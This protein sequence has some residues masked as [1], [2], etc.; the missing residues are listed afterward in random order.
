MGYKSKFHKFQRF[1]D[2]PGSSG[3][4]TRA[5]RSG[6]ASTVAKST[7]TRISPTGDGEEGVFSNHR[8]TYICSSLIGATVSVET[9]D[10]IVYEGVFRTFSPDLDI[11]LEQVH[12]VDPEDPS[13]INPDTVKS[14]GMLI[15]LKNRFF[16]F[17]DPEHEESGQKDPVFSGFSRC[18]PRVT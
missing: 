5:D 8:V 16:K 6:P 11:T 7:D 15:F 18:E 12:Q 9:D 3:S 13:K 2:R 4:L 1:R 10:G 17:P 14:T